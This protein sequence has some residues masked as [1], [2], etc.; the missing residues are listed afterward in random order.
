[1]RHRCPNKFPAD[2]G[3]RSRILSER[4]L[5]RSPESGNRDP[6][7]SAQIIMGQRKRER[8]KDTGTGAGR[9]RRIPERDGSGG[10][11]GGGITLGGDGLKI[12]ERRFENIVEI[13]CIC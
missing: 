9:G 6:V 12:Q 3:I 7:P 2:T 5:A 8:R 13:E 10:T 11:S 4:T 1:M